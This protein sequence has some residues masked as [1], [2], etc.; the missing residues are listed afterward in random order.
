MFIRP[1]RGDSRMCVSW[2]DLMWRWR[3][4]RWA[5]VFPHPRGHR[6]L[7]LPS[8]TASICD[9]RCPL[10]SKRFPQ[11]WH[12][13]RRCEC[14]FGFVV[15]W[16]WFVCVTLIV[17]G[18]D[19]SEDSVGVLLVAVLILD[20][21]CWDGDGELPST[22]VQ[23]RE[24]ELCGML[25]GWFHELDEDF[26]SFVEEDFEWESS[27]WCGRDIVEWEWRRENEIKQLICC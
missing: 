22:S 12:P 27:L 4:E 26:E 23:K 7:L 17:D 1:S 24:L 3:D 6:W 10:L 18:R 14:G 2:C 21:I 15:A 11:M 8:C 13:K 19:G 9:S 20:D 25:G 16:F 5:N